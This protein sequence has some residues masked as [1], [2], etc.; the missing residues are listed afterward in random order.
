LRQGEVEQ[1]RS[2]LMH[3]NVGGLQNAMHDPFPARR[4]Q[5]LRDLQRQAQGIGHRRG[6]LK[7]SPSRYTLGR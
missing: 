5:C 1:L 3:E 6:P 2:A 7:I 4:G